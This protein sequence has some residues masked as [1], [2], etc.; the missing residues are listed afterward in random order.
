MQSG[1]LALE[2]ALRLLDATIGEAVAALGEGVRADDPI[3]VPYLAGERTPFMAAGL[4]GAWHGLGLSTNR[5]ALLRSVLE[6][7]AQAAALGVA[8]VR[9]SGVSLPPVV[10]LVGGGSHDPSFRQLLA[11]ATGLSLGVVDAPDAAVIGAAILA[12]GAVRADEPV[13]VTGSR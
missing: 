6:G 3:F 13:A 7:V 4:Q 10:P 9:D 5:A 8:A 2:H 12:R 1:G 11:D